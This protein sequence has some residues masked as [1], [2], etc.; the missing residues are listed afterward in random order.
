M[1]Y[2]SDEGVNVRRAP[3]TKALIIYESFTTGWFDYV[4]E[5]L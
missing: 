2:S 5:F 1:D 4:G 3:K